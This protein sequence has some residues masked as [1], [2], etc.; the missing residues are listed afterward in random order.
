VLE[1]LRYGHRVGLETGDFE[2]SFLTSHL[3]SLSSIQAGVPLN[4]VEKDVNGFCQLMVSKRHES[5]LQM[6]KVLLQTVHHFM[7]LTENPLSLSGDVIDYGKALDHATETDNAAFKM[8]ILSQR[9]WL[10]YIF[11]SYDLASELVTKWRHFRY[12]SAPDMFVSCLF[13]G[14]IAAAAARRHKQQRKRQL[15]ILQENIKTF[16][17]W[18]RVSPNNCQDKLFLLVAEMAS[19]RGDHELAFQKYTCAN[20]LA[21]DSKCLWSQALTNERAGEHLK[22]LGECDLAKP[23][24]RRACDLFAEWGAYAKVQ[25]LKAQLLATQG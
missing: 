5:T 13:D 22:A 20:A 12:N 6:A 23:F 9:T 2:F 25:Q 8:A 19:L 18:A 24:F 3:F 21:M 17:K 7:G 16:R 11:G 4:L 1:P 14:L 10:A 15:A